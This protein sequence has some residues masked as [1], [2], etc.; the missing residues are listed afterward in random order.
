MR[1][2]YRLPYLNRSYFQKT[3]FMNQVVYFT[4]RY[5]VYRFVREAGGPVNDKTIK[6]DHFLR[7]TCIIIISLQWL[8]FVC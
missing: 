3:G 6:R 5:T 1:F 8:R 4:I 7:L 2:I